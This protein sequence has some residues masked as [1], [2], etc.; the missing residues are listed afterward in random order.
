MANFTPGPWSVPHFA[1]PNSRCKCGYVLVDGYCGAVATIHFSVDRRL[2]NG[3]NPPLDEAIANAQI[4]AAA[5][6]MYAALKNARA[7][8]ECAHESLV[9]AEDKQECLES[10]DEAL[11]KADGKQALDAL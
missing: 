1:Q 5:P 3:D 6:D 8:V 4:I 7:F 11:A 9:N 10:I 2:E